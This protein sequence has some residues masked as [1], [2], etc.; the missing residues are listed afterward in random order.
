MADATPVEGVTPSES[1]V[2]TTDTVT[3]SDPTPTEVSS[4]D[5]VAEAPTPEVV[6]P[7]ASTDADEPE[8]QIA[9]EAA[10]VEAVADP[11]YNIID[12]DS[13]QYLVRFT[14]SNGLVLRKFV[15]SDEEAAVQGRVYRDAAV[16]K[17]F[18]LDSVTKA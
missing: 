17:G 2:P 5:A 6:A 12:T 3:P 18:T 7:E 10:I 11:V 8:V 13:T 14:F 1:S 16:K 15:T 9:A 4:V